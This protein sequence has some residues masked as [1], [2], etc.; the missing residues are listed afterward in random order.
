MSNPIMHAIILALAVVIPGGLLVYFTWWACKRRKQKNP[1]NQVRE[2][3]LKKYPP[4]SLR[5]LSRRQRLDA[6]KQRPRKKS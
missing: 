6:Y 1:Q 4:L 3:F 2:D 5:A